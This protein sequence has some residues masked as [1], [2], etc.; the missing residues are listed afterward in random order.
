MEYQKTYKGHKVRIVTIQTADN[1]WRSRAELLGSAGP[2]LE[3]NACSSEEESHHAAL[4]AVMAE[5]DRR[6]A[7][8]GKS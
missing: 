5:V 3:P 1:T 6:R 2:A 4:S 8:I 7:R